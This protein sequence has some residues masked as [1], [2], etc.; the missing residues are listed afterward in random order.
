[1]RKVFRIIKHELSGKGPKPFYPMLCRIE[2]K[3][4]LLFFFHWWSTPFGIRD[5][6]ENDCDAMKYIKE[7]YPDAIV[8]DY[9]SENKCKS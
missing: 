1:M 7:H 3:H 9:C 2:Q 5:L 8:Y 6:F 4:T